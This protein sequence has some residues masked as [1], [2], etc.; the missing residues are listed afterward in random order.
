MVLVWYEILNLA[1]AD[2][3]KGKVKENSE[4]SATLSLNA[5]RTI[6]EFFFESLYFQEPWVILHIV[7]QKAVAVLN[8]TFPAQD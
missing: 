1:D 5:S 7:K 3:R 8:Y 6:C 4:N 2:M